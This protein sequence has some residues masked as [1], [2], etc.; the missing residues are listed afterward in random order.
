MFLQLTSDPNYARQSICHNIDAKCCSSLNSIR[1]T[2]S[3]NL[4]SRRFYPVDILMTLKLVLGVLNKIVKELIFVQ[5][6]V[7]VFRFNVFARQFFGLKN[8]FSIEKTCLH[9]FL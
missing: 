1:S 5:E 3:K 2:V 9:Q 6:L 8:F 7:I 4:T